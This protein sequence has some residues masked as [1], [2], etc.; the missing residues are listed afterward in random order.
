MIGGPAEGRVN[1]RETIVLADEVGVD[2]SESGELKQVIVKLG[3]PHRPN[4]GTVPTQRS[5]YRVGEPSVGSL[6]TI[7]AGTRS[8]K[9]RSSR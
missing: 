8:C 5:E 4:S 6:G 1:E 9:H 7:V 3:G 2:R